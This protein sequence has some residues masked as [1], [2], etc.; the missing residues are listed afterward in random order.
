MTGNTVTPRLFGIRRDRSSLV[1]AGLVAVLGCSPPAG[2]APAPVP[3]AADGEVE[4]MLLLIGDAGEPDPAGDVV[5]Q[6]AARRAGQTPGRTV[7][8]FL[9][10]NVYPN[11]MPPEGDRSRSRSEERLSL[12]IDVAAQSGARSIFVPGNHDWGDGGSDGWRRL[13]RQRALVAAR[14]LSSVS[15]L[16]ENGCPGPTAVDVSTTVRLVILDSQWW[17]DDELPAVVPDS[18]CPVNSTDAVLDSLDRLLRG[19]SGRETIIVTH[20]P[21]A[22]HGPHGGHFGLRDHIFPLRHLHS[23]LWIPLPIV[24]SVYPLIRQ[25]GFKTQ[26]LSSSKYESMRRELDSLFA[27]H[28]PFAQVAGHEH[29]LQIL[30]HTGV[31]YIFISGAGTYNHSTPVGWGEDTVFASD[32]SGFITI[33][34]LTDGRKRVG[35]T[36]VGET[37]SSHEVFAQWLE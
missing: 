12:L 36:V 18:V 20:H 19:A 6:A 23:W 21:L 15:F 31:E 29:N 3:H 35:V 13:E 1:T 2:V 8:L 34:F 9:G 17:F 11:G 37:G 26:D 30:R 32:E 24:G 28:E 22:S 7:V 33:S 27:I 25:A 5:L 16:P 10:D 4:L 14:G